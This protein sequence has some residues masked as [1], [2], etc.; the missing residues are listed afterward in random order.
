VATPAASER[1]TVEG[2]D[3]AISAPIAKPGPALSRPVRSPPG[4]FITGSSAETVPGRKRL[5]ILGMAPAAKASG[6]ACSGPE[7]AGHRRRHDAVHA[8]GSAFSTCET[9]QGSGVGVA[10]GGPA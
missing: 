9:E 2:L 6:V 4:L 8:R 7:L 3:A 1:L 10:A 5:M